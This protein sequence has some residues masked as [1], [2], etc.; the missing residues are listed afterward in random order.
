MGCINEEQAVFD[1]FSFKRLQEVKFHKI[2]GGA[3]V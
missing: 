3:V 2:K 1:Q